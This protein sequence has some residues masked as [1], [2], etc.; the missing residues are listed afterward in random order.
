MTHTSPSEEQTPTDRGAAEQLAAQ[1]DEANVSD[2]S[3]PDDVSATQPSS[4]T[5]AS[6]PVPPRAPKCPPAFPL[7]TV[8]LVDVYVPT[9]AAA[10]VPPVLIQAK[11]ALTEEMLQSPRRRLKL[12]LILFI[13]T[14]LSTFWVGMTLWMPMGSV[15]TMMDLRQ[16]LVG[17]WHTGLI[18]MVCVLG[19][20]FAHE[21]G[22]FLM[23]VRY[24]IPS[25]FPFFLPLPFAPIGTIGAVMSMDGRKANRRQLFDIGIA[26]PIAGLVVALPILWIGI[27][28]MDFTKPSVGCFW[29]DSPLVVDA[30]LQQIRPP[31]DLPANGAIRH[32]NPY[33]MAGWV[34]LLITGLNMMPISQLDGGHVL[35]TLFGRRARWIARGVLLASIALVVFYFERAFIWTLM[36]VLVTLLGTDH[37]PSAD[38]SMPLGWFRTVLGLASLSIPILCFPPFGLWPIG[39]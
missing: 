23:T 21:M 24:R 22:H 7:V 35:Y 37:P 36:I 9:P 11:P 16:T 1:T 18:Y 5:P 20:L 39:M 2:R 19:I 27:S 28:Q 13:V 34:G 10:Q 25:S 38:D 33:F 17:H 8:E 14:C 15:F 29:L 26:G 30:M 4:P 31:G 32:L 12:P 3:A 6:S